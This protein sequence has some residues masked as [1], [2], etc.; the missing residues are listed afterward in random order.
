MITIE[1]ENEDYLEML[2]DRVRFWTSDDTTLAL[3]E[4]HYKRVVDELDGQTVTN[5]VQEIVDND[6]VNYYS[7]MDKEELKS[8][9]P[10]DWEERIDTEIDGMYLVNND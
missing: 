1:I 3:F 8:N 5:T 6:Y 4:E 9:Y 2:M 10:D 7:V